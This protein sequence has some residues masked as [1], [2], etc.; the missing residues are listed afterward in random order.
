MTVLL[1]PQKYRLLIFVESRCRT[2]PAERMT[3]FG[4]RK[5]VPHQFGRT[6]PEEASDKYRDR[7]RE[8]RRRRWRGKPGVLASRHPAFL[9]SGFQA[10]APGLPWRKMRLRLPSRIPN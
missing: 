3:S 4:L 5:S 8:S 10:T 6:H 7:Y 9:L 1:V 2:L